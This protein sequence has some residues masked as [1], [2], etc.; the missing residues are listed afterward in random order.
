[1]HVLFKS[2]RGAGG[3]IQDTSSVLQLPGASQETPRQHP[4]QKNLPSVFPLL[5]PLSLCI[6]NPQ[7]SFSARNQAFF[8]S[9]PT[10][11]RGKKK[12]SWVVHRQGWHSVITQ[13]TFFISYTSTCVA[14]YLPIYL[15]QLSKYILTLHPFIRRAMRNQFQKKKKRNQFQAYLES[16]KMFLTALLCPLFFPSFPSW[17][18]SPHCLLL[19]SI[20]GRKHTKKKKIRGFPRINIDSNRGGLL[21]G[22]DGLC[23]GIPKQH[24]LL[25]LWF[26]STAIGLPSFPHQWI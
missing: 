15:I 23:R 8:L 16:S 6:S 3:P 21:S 5:F 2:R 20:H 19:F 1:M 22:K 10:V 13:S 18:F 17:L 25:F 12:S 24:T 14:I 26:L 7:T 9:R 4:Q 11:Q